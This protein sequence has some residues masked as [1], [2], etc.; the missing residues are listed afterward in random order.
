ME[1]SKNN[2]V[3]C[4]IKMPLLATG[5]MA[6]LSIAGDATRYRDSSLHGS[7]AGSSPM[8]DTKRS[9]RNS[10]M[11]D[12]P[13]YT[14]TFNNKSCIWFDKPLCMTQSQ[15]IREHKA[16][17][18]FCFD[19]FLPVLVDKRIRQSGTPVRPG[20]HFSVSPCISRQIYD[21]TPNK[22]NRIKKLVCAYGQEK[23]LVEIMN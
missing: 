8:K 13:N 20:E 7:T 1:K 6:S 16:M 4:P 9:S 17:N 11:R 2:Q 19:S 21:A 22:I 14:S 10:S 3:E 18:D 23:Q 5:K 15:S 12:V